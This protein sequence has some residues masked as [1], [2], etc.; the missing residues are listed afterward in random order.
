MRAHLTKHHAW[1]AAAVAAVA[2]LTLS[3]AHGQGA[4]SQ[5]QFE[6]RPA[7]AG[8]Q[9]GTGAMA[10]PPQGGLGPQSVGDLPRRGDA[11]DLPNRVRPHGDRE[12]PH[13]AAPPQ[14]DRDPGVAKSQRSLRDKLL[15]SSKRT[16]DA[17]RHGVSPIDSE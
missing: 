7:M 2:L 6:G 15:R 10:G 4:G 14:R 8:A 16:R 12:P 5:A 11:S 13:D 17:A 9:A 1:L 3:D